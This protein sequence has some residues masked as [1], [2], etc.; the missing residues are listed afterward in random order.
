MGKAQGQ[1]EDTGSG[2]ERGEA[3]QAT[4]SSQPESSRDCS[5]P[6]QGYLALFAFGK[7]LKDW[8]DPRGG[9]RPQEETKAHP[10]R[11]WRLGGMEPRN[12]QME[13]VQAWPRRAGRE[14]LE[15]RCLKNA[16]PP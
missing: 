14:G 8:K 2:T 15:S 16:H 1:L 3:G 13:R 4:F 11:G 9:E 5:F 12:G 10:T 7:I 6:S